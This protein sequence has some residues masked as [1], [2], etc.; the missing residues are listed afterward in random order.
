M[1]IVSITD[2]IS[3]GSYPQLRSQTTHRYPPG[4]SDQSPEMMAR[5]QPQVAQSVAR[6]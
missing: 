3:T 1:N 2:T 5:C 4:L 6:Q